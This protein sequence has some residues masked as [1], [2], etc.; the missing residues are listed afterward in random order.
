VNELCLRKYLSNELNEIGVP[1]RFLA[2]PFLSIPSS[3]RFKETANENRYL[4]RE[5]GPSDSVALKP[6]TVA[7]R[8]M[9]RIAFAYQLVDV[10]LIT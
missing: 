1:R 5:V 6:A 8:E 10:I 9:I 3:I 2:P 4:F 7:G